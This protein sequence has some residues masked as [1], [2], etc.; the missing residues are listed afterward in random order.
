MIPLKKTGE[1][2]FEFACHEGTYGLRAFL[3]GARARP[4][5]AVSVFPADGRKITSTFVKEE[6]HGS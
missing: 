2:M 3:S 5:D 4:S 6:G 1:Q